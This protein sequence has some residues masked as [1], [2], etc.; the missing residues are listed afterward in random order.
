MGIVNSKCYYCNKP[1]QVE[2][3]KDAWICPECGEPF[4]VEKSIR[5]SRKSRSPKRVVVASVKAVKKDS[6]PVI[7]EQTDEI[8]ELEKAPSEAVEIPAAE[9]VIEKAPEPIPVKREQ[10]AVAKTYSRPSI[11]IEDGVLVK[12]SGSSEEIEL[13]SNVRKIGEN[14][15][16]NC[17]KIKKVILPDGLTE[18]GGYAFRNCASLVSIKIPDSLVKIGPWAFRGCEKLESMRL[19]NNISI[20][21]DCVFAECSSLKSVEMSNRVSEIRAFAFN[22]CKNLESIWLPNTVKQIGKYAF[23][24]CEKLKTVLVPDGV[25]TI[26]ERTFAGCTNLID[27]ELPKTLKTIG[28]FAFRKC[29]SLKKIAIP[30]AV[31]SVD[32]FSGCT[33]LRVIEIPSKATYIGDFSGCTNLEMIKIPS[34]VVKIDTVFSDCPKLMNI[35]WQHL[36]ENMSRFPAY[37]EKVIADRRA[38]GKCSFCG[39]DF[40]LLTKTCKECGKKKDY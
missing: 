1:V 26:N 30:F 19:P 25:S 39:G 29:T 15:F 5:L 7:S 18:I 24:G 33:S 21:D 10:A 27:I 28:Q 4:I 14:A 37:H 20:I 34:S 13:P 31:A 6:V 17:D 32:G 23:S 11:E 40:K 38:S 16:E 2:E 36:S 35:S 12:Y 22:G 8:K 9:K 3:E